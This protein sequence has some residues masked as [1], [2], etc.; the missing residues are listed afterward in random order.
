MHA[1]DHVST[2]GVREA[3]ILLVEDL[4]LHRRIIPLRLGRWGMGIA[5]VD[6]AESAEQYLKG[7]V[8]DLMLLDVMLPGKDGFTLCRELKADPATKDMAIM[9]FTELQ[10]DAFNLSLEAQAD[11][12]FP[13]GAQDIVLRTRVHLH[14][15]LQELRQ[16][17][18]PH[19]PLAPGNILLAT[20]ARSLRTHL[21]LEAHLDGHFMRTVGS[22]EEVR[23]EAN[24]ED[25]LL[26]VDAALGID[27]VAET[28]V[29]LR[30]QPA[31]E[32]IGF[33]LLC[34]VT[35]LS[36]IQGL[37]SLVDDALWMPMKPVLARQ[38]MHLGVELG[39]R[40]KEALAQ[41]KPG[42]EF[43]YVNAAAAWSAR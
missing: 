35:E 37:L 42:P 33:L 6:D 29:Q 18:S 24:S 32:G 9:M 16:P 23:R 34:Q 4:P 5:V 40:R 14:L 3:R 7:R 8:P 25:A 43:P 15:Q 21:P 30:S 17:G 2:D 1:E 20:D 36:V 38:R 26:V 22:L 27:A 19:Q 28:I 10:G 13:K 39:Q 41:A 12:Y 11:D 31:T